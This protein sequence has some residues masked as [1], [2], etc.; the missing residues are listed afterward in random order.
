MQY[1]Q[2]E[3]LIGTFF[4]ATVG[5]G[6]SFIPLMNE[7]II[8]T[9]YP[10]GTATSTGIPNWLVGPSSGG[11]VALS[12]LIPLVDIDDYPNSV[13]RDAE[14]QDLSWFL[15]LMNGFG[16]VYYTSLLKFGNGIGNGIFEIPD[17]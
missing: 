9:T 6:L 14:S 17:F 4:I 5:S 16:L 12:S 10:V 3:V 11:L 13:C 7:L 15:M 1:A 2:N 8:E